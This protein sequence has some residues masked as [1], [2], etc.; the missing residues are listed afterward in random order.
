MTALDTELLEGVEFPAEVDEGLLQDDF[1]SFLNA[2]EDLE[3]GR[4]DTHRMSEVKDGDY[5]CEVL[6]ATLR[7]NK[8]RQGNVIPPLLTLRIRCDRPQMTTSL[9]WETSN[10][11]STK[12]NEMNTRNL[13]RMFYRVLGAEE[14]ARVGRPGAED[15]TPQAKAAFYLKLAQRCIGRNAVARFSTDTW[16]DKESGEP[17]SRKAVTLVAAAA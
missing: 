6:D 12:V 4:M 13:M 15:I 5:P 14:Y 8:D 9:F 11:R 2:G 10:Y 1:E 7:T 17:R 3:A 16:T